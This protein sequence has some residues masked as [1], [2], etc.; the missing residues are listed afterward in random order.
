MRLLCQNNLRRN[1][2]PSPNIVA[3]FGAFHNLETLESI[4]CTSSELRRR[5][6]ITLLLTTHRHKPSRSNPTREMLDVYYCPAVWRD[7]VLKSNDNWTHQ[8][9]SKLSHKQRCQQS[10]SS[11]VMSETGR[12]YLRYLTLKSYVVEE[13]YF[14]MISAHCKQNQHNIERCVT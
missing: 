9:R 10:S 5:E 3:I 1:L 13:V 6:N 2:D 11:H 12:L 7:I 14:Q 8:Y 4:K